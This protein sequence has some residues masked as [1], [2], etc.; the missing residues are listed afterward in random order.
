MAAILRTTLATQMRHLLPRGND[1]HS[2]PLQSPS[3]DDPLDMSWVEELAVQAGFSVVQ[4]LVRTLRGDVR[5]AV[6]V[7]LAS[8]NRPTGGMRR[9]RRR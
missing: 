9:M 3:Q 2:Q 8:P 6:D 7:L 5:G 1:S 4:A